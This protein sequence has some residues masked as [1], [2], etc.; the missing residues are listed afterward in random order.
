[1]PNVSNVLPVCGITTRPLTI[2]LQRALLSG[3]SETPEKFQALSGPREAV[4]GWVQVSELDVS[5]DPEGGWLSDDALLLRFE[6]G[7]QHEDRFNLSG[8]IKPQAA[9]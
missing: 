3:D 7:V 4:T 1:M 2:Q 6:I 8:E 9:R 5:K